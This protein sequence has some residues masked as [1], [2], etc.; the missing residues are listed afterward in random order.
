[1]YRKFV[2]SVHGMEW[3]NCYKFGYHHKYLS[4]FADQNSIIFS[5]RKMLMETSKFNDLS[6][7][8][9]QEYYKL[10]VSFCF[11]SKEKIEGINMQISG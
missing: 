7:S 2:C 9:Q 11:C 4:T 3:Y 8:I 5:P 1:M 6:L 10:K